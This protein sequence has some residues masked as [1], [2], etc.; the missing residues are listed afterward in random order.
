MVFDF[1]L[2]YGPL[3]ICLVGNIVKA[4]LFKVYV[5]PSEPWWKQIVGE[6]A[7]IVIMTPSACLGFA[8]RYFLETG[9]LMPDVLKKWLKTPI[10]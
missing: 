3:K 1:C 10:E 7:S 5:L 9:G 6:V 4:L 8:L 2:S